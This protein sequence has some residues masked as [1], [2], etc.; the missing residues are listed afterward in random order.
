MT[1]LAYSPNELSP[2]SS[3]SPPILDPLLRYRE[4][5]DALSSSIP[6]PEPGGNFESTFAWHAT[7]FAVLDVVNRTGSAVMEFSGEG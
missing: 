5:M 6:V 4:N 7:I 3:V 2:F 1:I